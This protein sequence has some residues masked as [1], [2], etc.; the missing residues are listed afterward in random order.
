[1]SDEITTEAEAIDALEGTPPYWRTTSWRANSHI[2]H[3]HRDCQYLSN[4]NGRSDNVVEADPV[5]L[6]RR[7]NRRLCKLCAAND[8]LR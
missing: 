1:M 2:Y 4:G 3:T 5:Q 7:G 8:G 6:A